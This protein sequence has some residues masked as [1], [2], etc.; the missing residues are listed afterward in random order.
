[1]QNDQ[2]GGFGNQAL[3]PN[4]KMASAPTSIAPVAVDTQD[5]A[6]FDNG[7]DIRSNGRWLADATATFKRVRHIPVGHKI[8]VGAVVALSIAI[9]SIAGIEA[10]KGSSSAATATNVAER[11]AHTPSVTRAGHDATPRARTPVKRRVGVPVTT[12]RR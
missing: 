10:M 2:A 11:S 3:V 9:V 1:M 8:V 4:K 12:R 7:S 6:Y 5:D